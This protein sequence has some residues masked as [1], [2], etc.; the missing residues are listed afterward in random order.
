MAF[1][2]VG[3]GA[4]APATG[5]IYG[6]SVLADGTATPV[7]GSP[8]NG[9][10]S[11]VLT[12]GAYVFSTDGHNIATYAR[13]NNGSLQ[14]PAVQ[15]AIPNPGSPNA[16]LIGSLSLD[17]TGQTIYATE[18]AG[19]DDN[20]IFFFN[21]G[22]NGA[23]SGT[24][25]IGP[26]VDYVSSLVFSPDNNYAYGYGC[27]HANWDVTG[28]KRNSD[29]TLTKLGSESTNP[30][31]PPFAA[32]GQMYCPV[33]EAVSAG[34][35]LAVA[36][37]QLGT[38][39]NYSI[40]VFHINSDGSLSFVSST[41]TAFPSGSGCCGGAQ[42]TF[43]F[44]PTGTYLAAADKAGLQMFRLVPG[45]ILAPIGGLQQPG[46]NYQ[47]VQWDQKDHV[48]AISDSQLY[49][50]KNAEG[51]LVPAPGSPSAT[52]GSGSLTVLPVL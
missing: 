3:G 42:V 20:Y 28:F 52:A 17:H 13:S 46:P 16:Y 33:A 14:Q 49:V 47:A 50:F 38:N 27:F 26:N 44:D 39:A 18:D 31:V 48:Y 19:A 7:Q 10:N 2:Y 37:A 1:A 41:D 25:Q 40:V 5:P 11:N 22:A 15:N 34:G 6:F 43:T 23:I 51:K 35:Y 29:G 30:A 12:N 45:G 36:A 8:T 21:V 24:G 4:S 32:S 9:P